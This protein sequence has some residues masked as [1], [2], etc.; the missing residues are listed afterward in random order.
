MAIA[1]TG[2]ANGDNDGGEFVWLNT[3]YENNWFT[4]DELKSIA[5][6]YNGQ[7]YYGE[8]DYGEGFTPIIK[9]PSELD[10]ATKEKIISSYCKEIGVEEF[11]DSVSISA[12]YGTYGDCIVIDLAAECTTGGGDPNFYQEYRLGGIT[13][14][15]YSFIGVYKQNVLY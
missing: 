11:R 8:V 14:Y 6:Y 2:C 13:F 4:G 15:N 9:N 1:V 7:H 12:Y 5:Y 3:A 10:E